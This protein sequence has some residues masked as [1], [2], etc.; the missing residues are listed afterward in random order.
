MHRPF[1]RQEPASVDRSSGWASTTPGGLSRQVPDS[2]T[3][4]KL[5]GQIEMLRELRSANA[6]RF[7]VPFDPVL[8]LS[9]V[10]ATYAL[11]RAAELSPN[12]F[13]T[14]L[15]LQIAYDSRLMYEAALPIVN[16]LM[17]LQTTNLYQ[18]GEQT[19]TEAARAEYLEKLGTAPTDDLAKLERPGSN[20]ERHAH[21]RPRRGAADLLEKTYPPEKAT[22]EMIDKMATL[23]LHLGEPA[24]RQRSLAESNGGP[25][26]GRRGCAHRHDLPG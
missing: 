22:W 11:R 26:T 2:A 23:R 1:L 10:R 18:A 13:S 3:A 6:P 21:R 20:R 25:S 9:I 8:D 17:S 16:R 4:W 5:L 15:S 14:L 19:K 24:L 12:D 7:R